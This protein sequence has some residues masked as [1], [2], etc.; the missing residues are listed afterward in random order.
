MR[1]KQCGTWN[2]ARNTEKHG[3]WEMHIVGH[4]VWHDNWKT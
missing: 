2:M 1:Y 4:G 3:K